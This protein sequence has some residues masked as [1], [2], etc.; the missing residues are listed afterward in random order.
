M[1]TKEEAASAL[2]EQY[3]IFHSLAR[4]TKEF[5][6]LHQSVTLIHQTVGNIQQQRAEMRV[7]TNPRER[8]ESFLSINLTLEM[9]KQTD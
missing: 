7:K 5:S 4:V 8:T 1:D 3:F 6:A 2:R 9:S